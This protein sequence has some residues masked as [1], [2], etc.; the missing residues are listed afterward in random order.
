MKQKESTIFIYDNLK[1]NTNGTILGFAVKN[2][3][4]VQLIIK[5]SYINPNTKE[6]VLITAIGD[7][8]FYNERLTLLN[9]PDSITIIGDNAFGSSAF[10]EN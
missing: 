3:F 7:N 10:K 8:A 6:K 2:D 9:I 5:E 1:I 4:P